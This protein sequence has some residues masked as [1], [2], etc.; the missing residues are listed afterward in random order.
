MSIH[1]TNTLFHKEDNAVHFSKDFPGEK[2]FYCHVVFESEKFIDYQKDLFEDFL[3][4]VVDALSDEEGSLEEV[5]VTFE[6]ELQDLN[7]KLSVF[8]EKIKDVDTFP[9]K[10]IVQ[11]FYGLEY[12]ASLIGDMGII[13][14]RDKKLNYMMS[15]Q[16]SE[17]VKIQTFSEMIE[18]EV[19]EYDEIVTLGV[20]IDTYIDR[21][22]IQTI[23]QVSKQEE[24]S[25]VDALLDVLEV[26]VAK[27][28]IGFVSLSMVESSSFFT[29]KKVEKKMKD[30]LHHLWGIS[31]KILPYQHYLIYGTIAIF[32][33]LLIYWLV[34]SFLSSNQARFIE[35]TN[36]VVVDFTIED[37][38]KD[39]AGFKRRDASSDEKIK[40]YHE[41]MSQL[42]LLTER[43][44]WVE[45]VAKLRNIL[46]T[47][48]YK[49]FNITLINSDA[50]LGDP[51][52]EFS[53]QEKN[54][55]GELQNIFYKD[56]LMIWGKEWVL[57]GAINDQV[58][59]TL[60]SA[61]ADMKF[62]WCVVNLLKN[63]LYCYTEDDM[64]YNIVKWWQVN[65]VSNVSGIFPTDIARLGTFGSSNFYVLTNDSSLNQAGTYIVRYNNKIGTQETFT[66]GTEYLLDLGSWS[67]LWSWFNSFAIDGSFL[68]WSPKDKKLY[69]LRRPGAPANLLMREISLKW[70]DTIENYTQDT[71]V[72][73]F[74]T[75][76]FVYLFDKTNQT[77]TVYRSLPYKTNNLYEHDY[78]L[79]YFFRIKFSLA[80]KEIIDVYV[81]EGERSNLYLLTADGVYTFAL[82]EAIESYFKQEAEEN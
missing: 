53:Q 34:Q 23:Q 15:N 6:R 79:E 38:Q 66:E 64:I 41:I 50:L 30:H 10:G 75:S 29:Q 52:Y 7:T 68:T 8:A 24:K 16:I 26:R 40:K 44:R 62:Q 5:K 28:Q 33:F 4:V 43:N 47:E 73:A 11:I 67:A 54:I 39:I 59:G 42:D 46:E 37:I 81:D 27:E 70:W 13:V 36:G 45:D 57:L 48:Y 72:I 78:D 65:P 49:W 56:G 82:Y 77:F 17:G 20:P 63:G 76:R 60:V 14:L 31:K 25:F 1:Y 18:G 21:H 51:M 55:F 19:K 35:T 12:M 71:K 74:D 58:R 61:S 80:D 69:Q 22:D 3:G 9:I 32:A 2:S